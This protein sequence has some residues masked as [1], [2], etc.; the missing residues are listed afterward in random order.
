MTRSIQNDS[1]DEALKID[2]ELSEMEKDG[3]RSINSNQTDD[4]DSDIIKVTEIKG[5]CTENM[6]AS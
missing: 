3:R 1:E 4:E 2:L 5:G 6:N